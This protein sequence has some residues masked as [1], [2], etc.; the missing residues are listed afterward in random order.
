MNNEPGSS[1]GV[2]SDPLSGPDSDA[3]ASETNE[4]LLPGRH[5]RLTQ[6]EFRDGTDRFDGLVHER[7]WLLHPSEK[8]E[9]QGNLFCI[10]TLERG[11]QTLFIQ[12]APLPHARC[13]AVGTDLRAAL[14]TGRGLV[15][16]LC[17]GP[18]TILTCG[19]GEWA[20]IRTLRD[21]Q[22]GLRPAART[23]RLPAFLSNTWGD[24]SRDSRMNQAFIEAEVAAAGRLGVDVVQL[25]DGW[26][27]GTT[28]NSSDNLARGGVWEGFWNADPA[29]WTPH[30]ERFPQGLDPLARLIA[31]HG[32]NLGLWFAPDSWND[33][34]N[35]EKDAAALLELHRSLGVCH[36]KIDAIRMSSPSSLGRIR[37][38]V[39]R[40]LEQSGGK[41]VFDL[42]IT[43]AVRPGYFGLIECGPLF[44]ENRYT[45]WVNHWPHRTLRNL[46]QLAR[47]IDP[48]R[49]RMEFLN[50]GRNQALYGDDPLAPAH[51]R[52]D[53]LFATVMAA[54]PLG[55]FEVTG[56][57]DRYI[58]EVAALVRIWKEHREAMTAGTLIPV[59]PCPD[60]FNHS[61]FLIVP[62]EGRGHWYLLLF[63][64]QTDG[65]EAVF[66]LPVTVP[67]EWELLAGAGS[68]RTQ[69]RRIKLTIDASH[70]YLF[71]VSTGRRA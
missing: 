63:R 71:G 56:L 23:H 5:F 36:F 38:M 31:D 28:A 59:G 43:A 22:R 54:N 18:W 70:S 67:G 47:W 69:G 19:A 33:F 16:S 9:L 44:V 14:D 20:R 55:W 21:W 40:V 50:N 61:G 58:E 11:E 6:V 30:P 39:A 48:L 1:T 46:W 29:F 4:H 65:G 62:D 7:E 26:Q 2:E 24:R 57:S 41:V 52:P 17:P 15:V 66:D 13:E 53:A 3:S 25:D 34:A 49:L 68:L 42:D 32:M 35:W 12:T 64:G 51:Y 45:D 27:K 37:A 10:E 60:G 8:L